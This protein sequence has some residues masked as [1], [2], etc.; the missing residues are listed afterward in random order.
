MSLTFRMA[1]NFE[2]LFVKLELMYETDFMSFCSQNSSGSQRYNLLRLNDEI[3]QIYEIFN[4]SIRLWSQETLKR[5]KL[6]VS[7]F[8]CKFD[9]QFLLSNIDC[10]EMNSSNL[11][12]KAIPTS[13]F[14][15]KYCSSLINSCGLLLV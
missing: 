7:K 8:I 5:C 9:S 1:A 15:T 6:L 4:S 3:H 2:G 13:K 10:R 12:K 14:Y 11:Y